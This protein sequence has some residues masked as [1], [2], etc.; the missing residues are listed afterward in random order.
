MSAPTK[1]ELAQQALFLSSLAAKA[2]ERLDTVRGE[3]ETIARDELARDGAAPTWRIPGVGTVPLALTADAVE[4][5]DETAYLAYVA[6]RYPEQ[7]ERRVRPAFDKLLREQAAKR[8]AALDDE[9][10]VIPGCL[11]R[12]GGQPR[13]ISIRPAAPAKDASLE[14]AEAFVDSLLQ[15]VLEVPGA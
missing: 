8:G 13:G 4:V 3:L 11:F 1:A 14:L 12:P 9:G 6:V 7:I 10:T 5:V 15:S 2:K